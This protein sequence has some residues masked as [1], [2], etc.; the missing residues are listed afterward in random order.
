MSMLHALE[1]RVPFLDHRIV[2]YVFQI[3]PE[4]INQ[5]GNKYLL[6]KI[7]EKKFGRNFINQQKKGFGMKNL[8]L[9]KENNLS[10]YTNN[11]DMSKNTDL[12]LKNMITLLGK[13]SK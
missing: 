5:R 6:K 13:L 4:L 8:I 2:E 3:N 9:N 11:F 12:K 10:K 1:V 7:A